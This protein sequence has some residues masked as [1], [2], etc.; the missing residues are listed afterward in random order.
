MKKIMIACAAV[1]MAAVAQAASIDWS[2]SMNWTLAGGGKA[3]AGTVVYLIDATYAD[4][5]AAAIG[6]DGTIAAGTKGLLGSAAT[7]GA[8]GKVDL[9]TATHADLAAGQSYNFALLI[10]DKTDADQMY[11]AISQGYEQNAYTVGKDEA[12]SV[13]FGSAM[14]NGENAISYANG[15]AWQAVP[16]PTSGLLMLVGLAGLARRRRRA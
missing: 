15:T 6:E 11:Y 4:S 14:I 9:T 2:V 16:E 10:V 7:T 12:L 5:L 13:A 8:R 1:V 3:A